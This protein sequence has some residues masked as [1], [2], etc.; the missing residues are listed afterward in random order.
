MHFAARLTLGTFV[1]KLSAI[2]NCLASRCAL[3]RGVLSVKLTL[4]SVVIL[5]S[6]PRLLTSNALSLSCV[7]EVLNR[8]GN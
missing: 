1:N 2:L 4:N 7:G 5:F 8:S 6:K 3:P